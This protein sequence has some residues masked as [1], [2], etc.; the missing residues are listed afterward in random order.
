[1]AIT[2]YRSDDTSAPALSPSTG[3]GTYLALLKACLVD[4]YGAKSAAGWTLEFD[5]IATNG[6]MIIRNN[7]TTGTGRYFRIQD[8]GYVDETAGKAGTLNN[9]ATIRGCET[10]TDINTTSGNFPN[11]GLQGDSNPDNSTVT[12]ILQRYS[13]ITSYT[14]LPWMITADDRTVNIL[15]FN[16]GNGFTLPNA[17][18]NDSPHIE[19]LGDFE[20]LNGATNPNACLITGYGFSTASSSSYYRMGDGSISAGYKYLNRGYQGNAGAIEFGFKT[21]LQLYDL[22]QYIGAP[23]STTDYIEWDYP[24]AVVGGIVYS[25]IIIF[26]DISAVENTD[27]LNRDENTLQGTYRGMKACGHKIQGSGLTNVLGSFLDEVTIDGD[28]YALVYTYAGSASKSVLLKITGD[29]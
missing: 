25:D 22:F 7:P 29:M 2:V 17:L 8:N 26:E 20:P 6:V 16:S 4:G 27:S 9:F 14:N 12:G 28:D 24:N 5:D 21:S 18:Y 13:D 1:M 23:S 3:N 19:I 15:I 11:L 10:V